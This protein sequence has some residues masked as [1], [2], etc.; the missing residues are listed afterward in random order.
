[1]PDL[2]AVPYRPFSG[3]LEKNDRILQE[4][5]DHPTWFG[6][7]GDAYERRVLAAAFLTDPDNR[8]WEVWRGDAFIGILHLSAIVPQ[9]T[10]LWH[11][12]FTD[13]LWGKRALL[14]NFLGMLYRE[15]DLQSLQM[16]VPEPLSPLLRFCRAQLGFRYQG[17]ASVGG[18]PVAVALAGPGA[19]KPHIRDAPAWIARWGSRRERAHWY[20]DHWCDLVCL[21]QMRE[22][23]EEFVR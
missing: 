22:E 8:I 12:G 7:P 20:Q 10:A 2:L 21:V 11:F 9:V 23:Y 16:E 14:L 4:C 1:M 6:T 13:G 15:F 17:E 19:G 18:H 5:V 3:N